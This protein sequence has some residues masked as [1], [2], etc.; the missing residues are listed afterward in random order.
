MLKGGFEPASVVLN[1]P[2]MKELK[3]INKILENIP[4]KRKKNTTAKYY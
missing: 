3:K 2:P 4:K 1:S